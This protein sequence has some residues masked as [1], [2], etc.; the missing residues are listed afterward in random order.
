MLLVGHPVSGNVFGLMAFGVKFMGDKY[1]F[2][3]CDIMKGEQKSPDFLAMNP[4]HEVPSGKMADG[5]CLYEHAAMLRF[6]A[7][8]YAPET[9]PDD[10]KQRLLIDAAM[11]KRAG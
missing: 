1:K 3:M 2:Q 5:T 7:L 10:L 4:F 11:D 9:Y 8:K 6:L